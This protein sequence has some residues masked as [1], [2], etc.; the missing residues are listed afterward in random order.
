MAYFLVQVSY[1]TEGASN[2]VK[3]PQDRLEA[4]RPVAKKLGGTV[5][6]FWFSLGKY[7]VVCVCQ[8][9]DNVSATAFAMAVS[10]GGALKAI[11]TT[12]LLTVKE[13]ME[14]MKKAGGIGYQPPRS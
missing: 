2:L 4:I 3:N 1:S 5:D 9:P 11:R 8:M 6:H 10:A 14:S 13:G 7:D 12:P